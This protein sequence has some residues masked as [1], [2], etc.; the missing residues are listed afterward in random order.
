MTF[1]WNELGACGV[2]SF[3]ILTEIDRIILKK[4]VNV[5]ISSDLT[6]EN[7]MVFASIVWEITKH[8]FYCFFV[9]N[10]MHSMGDVYTI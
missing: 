8:D 5:H 7:I 3:D 4:K 2:Y 1:Y 6:D 9:F 10:K